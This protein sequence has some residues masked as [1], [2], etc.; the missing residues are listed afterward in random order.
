MLKQE[1]SNQKVEISI[2]EILKQNT[3]FKIENEKLKH[4]LDYF[5]RLIFGKK[6]ERFISNEPT[7]PPNTLFTQDAELIEEN[8]LENLSEEIVTTQ[9]KDLKI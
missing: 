5:R 1:T 6:S 7:L 9:Q 3:E 4:E 8:K 2:D